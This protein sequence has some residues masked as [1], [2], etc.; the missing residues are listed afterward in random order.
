MKVAADERC[1]PELPCLLTMPS[2]LRAV[3]LNCAAT[4]TCLEEVEGLYS[5]IVLSHAL[6]EVRL[7]ELKFD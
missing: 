3:W 6:A 7:K 4:H 2:L 1:Y 5:N